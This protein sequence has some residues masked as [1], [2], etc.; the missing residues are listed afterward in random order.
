[1]ATRAELAKAHAAARLRG[2]LDEA[3]RSALLTR[4]LE[5]TA[6]ALA[7]I[8]HSDAY[9]QAR[10]IPLTSDWDGLARASVKHMKNSPGHD[11]KRASAAD[12]EK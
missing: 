4:C 1:M 6:K 10:K 2:T 5:L 9:G 7:S 11:F 8:S 3:L 12:I